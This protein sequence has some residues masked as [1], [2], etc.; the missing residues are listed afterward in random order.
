VFTLNPRI[1][2]CCFSLEVL[3]RDTFRGAI[4]PTV[5]LNIGA[6]ISESAFDNASKLPR[7][8]AHTITPES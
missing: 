6:S 8:S 2:L 5:A 1:I 4:S 7:V 3:A